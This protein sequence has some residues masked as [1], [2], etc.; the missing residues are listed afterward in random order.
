MVE[1]IELQN[2]IK[3]FNEENKLDSSIEVKMLDLTSE[4]GELNKEVLKSSKYGKQKT[5]LTEDFKLELGDTIYSLVNVANHFN[6]SLEETLQLAL[7]KYEKRLKNGGIDS[8]H[9]K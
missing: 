3:V 6:I 9:K 2:K 7:N 4:V 5:E 1:L 8:Q